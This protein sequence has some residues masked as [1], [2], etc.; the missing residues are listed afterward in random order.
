MNTSMSDPAHAAI[1]A[2]SHT[3]AK[4]DIF[5]PQQINS[6]TQNHSRISSKN[7]TLLA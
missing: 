3:V 1:H 4:G 6:Y 7:D 5:R 2:A